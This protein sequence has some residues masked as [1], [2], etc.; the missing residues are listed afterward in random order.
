MTSQT[1]QYDTV[2]P[3]LGLIFHLP[4][5]CNAESRAISPFLGCRHLDAVAVLS[6]RCGVACEHHHASTLASCDF[7]QACSSHA[8]AKTQQ[9]LAKCS[10]ERRLCAAHACAGQ[11]RLQE[12]HI[13]LEEIRHGRHCCLPHPSCMHVGHELCQLGGTCLS[14]DI[15]QILSTGVLS[16]HMYVPD[17]TAHARVRPMSSA[18]S[19][20]D[21]QVV[22][23]QVSF[24]MR[25]NIRL[26]PACSPS[27]SCTQ[28]PCSCC[29]G[30]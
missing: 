8:P 18:A 19:S 7:R 23:P 22:I 6:T 2:L 13:C 5:S 12:R 16:G 15:I 3:L 24:F 20:P 27:P 10:R 30:C 21:F 29:P 14:H 17:R 25:A 11:Q 9:I 28:V 1:K 4:R 26:T